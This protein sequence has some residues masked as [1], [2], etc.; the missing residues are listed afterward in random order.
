MEVLKSEPIG[1]FLVRSSAT[2]PGCYALSLRVPEE[3]QPRGIAHY[4]ILK[5]HR[6]GYKIK[7]RA[8]MEGSWT[9]LGKVNLNNGDNPVLYLT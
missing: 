4:L 9:N 3:F 5:T 6:G 2:K 8:R 7:V 1:S